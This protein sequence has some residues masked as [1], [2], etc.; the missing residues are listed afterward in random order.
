MVKHLTHKTKIKGF[1]PVI[2]NVRD[3]VTKRREVYNLIH[4]LLKHSAEQ[5]GFRTTIK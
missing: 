4:G 3:K 2:G 5:K 1:N